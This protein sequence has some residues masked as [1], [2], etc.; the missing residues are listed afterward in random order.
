MKE[1]NVCNHCVCVTL[2]SVSIFDHDKESFSD[3]Y[4]DDEEE[5]DDSNIKEDND[6]HHTDSCIHHQP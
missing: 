2:V 1:F 4:D 6:D 5:D 3:D